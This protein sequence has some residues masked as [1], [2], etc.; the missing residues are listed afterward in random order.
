MIVSYNSP[1]R[2]QAYEAE[3]PCEA[4]PVPFARDL[5]ER[6]QK[7]ERVDLEMDEELRWCTVDGAPL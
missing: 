6:A 7:Q 4:D 2:M 5:V 3:I 1:F